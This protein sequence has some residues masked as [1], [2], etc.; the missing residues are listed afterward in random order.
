LFSSSVGYIA[1]CVAATGAVGTPRQ[2]VKSTAAMSANRQLD[3]KIGNLR[4]LGIVRKD[5][6]GQ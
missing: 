4:R 1:S 2:P 5:I 3:G 6:A